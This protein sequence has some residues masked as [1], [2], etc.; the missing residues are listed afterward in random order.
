MYESEVE[1]A[2]FAPLELPEFPELKA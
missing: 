1:E 2:H